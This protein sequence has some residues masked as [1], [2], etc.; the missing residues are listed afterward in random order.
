LEGPQL[1]SGW[2]AIGIPSTPRLSSRVPARDARKGTALGLTL[3]APACDPP[4]PA[5]AASKAACLP[6]RVRRAAPRCARRACR[7]QPGRHG[8][9]SNGACAPSIAPH[10][11]TRRRPN[12]TWR[13][14]RGRNYWRR[15]DVRLAPSGRRAMDGGCLLVSGCLGGG[16]AVSWAIAVR[17]RD[18]MRCG[19][20]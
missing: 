7:W 10:A 6:L 20:M 11:A 16:E 4:S 19:A 1:H 14:G 13:G 8:I 18:V 15:S 5:S 2:T 3:R 17:V 12:Q 9:L